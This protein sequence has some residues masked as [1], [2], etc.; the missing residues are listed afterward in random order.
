MQEIVD[1]KIVILGSTGSVGRQTVEVAKATK[2]RGVRRIA[3]TGSNNVKIMEREERMLRPS[4]C[5]M[6]DEA[7]AQDLKTKLA[8]TD[9][10]VRAGKEALLEAA[11]LPDADIVYNSIG[12]SAGLEPTLSAL[13]AGKTLALANK[14]SLVIA[15]EIVKETARR[16]NARYPPVLFVHY[17]DERILLLSRPR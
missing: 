8:D 12:Q 17:D 1:K 5:V 2:P 6:T 13:R 15:G 11:A 9:I 14:E 16:H 3:L 10:E 7:A 4:F